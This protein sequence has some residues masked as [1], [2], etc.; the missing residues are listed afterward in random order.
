MSPRCRNANRSP[1]GE[2]RGAMLHPCRV[3]EGALDAIGQVV[4]D[5]DVGVG[6]VGAI[7]HDVVSVGR[8]A[9]ELVAGAAK[10]EAPHPE[11]EGTEVTA[12]SKL[13]KRSSPEV[14]PRPRGPWLA[15]NERATAPATRIKGEGTKGLG[16]STAR[17][18]QRMGRAV[19]RASSPVPL[20]PSRRG[21][22]HGPRGAPGREPVRPS[23][24]RTPSRSASSVATPAPTLLPVYLRG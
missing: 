12:V 13:A 7:E 16:A 3:S 11:S 5:E 10:R 21:R 14:A 17:G 1:C 4:E 18:R 15:R 6:V 23:R 20:V 2:T 24:R 9:R 19:G 22:T 8:K